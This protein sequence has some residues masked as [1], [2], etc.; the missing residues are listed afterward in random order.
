MAQRESQ[1]LREELGEKKKGSGMKTA[2]AARRIARKVSM[3][4]FSAQRMQRA[5]E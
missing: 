2:V 5:N 1:R 4:I 3:T